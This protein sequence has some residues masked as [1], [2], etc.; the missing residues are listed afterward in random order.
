MHVRLPTTPPLQV[1]P[2]QQSASVVQLLVLQ[3]FPPTQDLSQHSLPVV[4]D[5]PIPPQQMP[6][7][8][9]PQ[10]PLQH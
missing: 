9:K 7:G 2:G 10:R 5:A 8:K 1:R 6:I 3:H 4:H